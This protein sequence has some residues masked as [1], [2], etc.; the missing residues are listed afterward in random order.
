MTEY[1]LFPGRHHVLTRF[2]GESKAWRNDWVID[3]RIAPVASI[4]SAPGDPI[5]WPVTHQL[6]VARR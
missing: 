5:E 6:L 4:T 2:Q 1:L 3:N